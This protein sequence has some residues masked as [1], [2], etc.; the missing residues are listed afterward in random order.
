MEL[1]LLDSFF[2]ILALGL[3][4][5]MLVRGAI[6]SPL[7]AL[8][9][10]SLTMTTSA[11]Y[12]FIMPVVALATGDPGYFGMFI[13]DLFWLHAADLRFAGQPAQYGAAGE[14]LCVRQRRIARCRCPTENGHRVIDKLF[15][16][17]VVA[18]HMHDIK[19]R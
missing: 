1:S 4:V 12:F 17:R 6:L 14:L 5:A 15:K 7:G 2:G 19:R 13:T 10:P 8:S 3:V 9:L 18:A 11:V 16:P